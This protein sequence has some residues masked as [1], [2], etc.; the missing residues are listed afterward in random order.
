MRTYYFRLIFQAMRSRP[1]RIVFLPVFLNSFLLAPSSPSAQEP[2]VSVAP[3]NP[4]FSAYRAASSGSRPRLGAVSGSGRALGFIP[5]PLDFSH[6]K[7]KQPVVQGGS[8]IPKLGYAASYDLRTIGKTSSVKDQGDTCGSCW[9]F[10][11]MASLESRL[12]TG[13]SRDFSEN[14]LK[15]T[16]GFDYTPCEGGDDIMATAYLARWSGPWNETADPY[17]S[18]ENQ[19]APAYP[20][21]NSQ[22]HIQEVLFLP[23]RASATSND[24]IKWALTNYGA[25]STSIYWEDAS[26]NATNKSYIYTGASVVNHGVTIVG[27]DDNYDGSKFNT[28]PAGNGAFIIK[29]SWGSSW[30]ESGY[31]YLSY[32]DANI[33]YNTVYIGAEPNANYY[34]VYQYDPLG[35]ISAKGYGSTLAWFSNVFTAVEAN[36]QVDAVGFYTTDVNS[37]YRIFVYSDMPTAGNPRSGTLIADQTGSQA[38]V[39]YH[40]VSLN[41]KVPLSNGQKFTVVIMMTTSGYNYPIPVESPESGYS[42]GATAGAGQSYISPDGDAWSDLTL[43]YADTNANIKAFTAYA[44]TTDSTP[45]TVIALVKDGLSADIAYTTST[46]QLSANW[47]ASNDPES[48]IRRYWYAIGT[49]AGGTGVVDWTDNGN[50]ISVTKTGLGLTNGATYYFTVK[51][52]NWKGLTSVPANSNGQAIDST[53]PPGPGAVNDGMGADVTYIYLGTQL[54]ANWTPAV[55]PQSG[56]ARYW[57]AIGTTAGGTDVAGWTD[58]GTSTSVTKTGLSLTN[59]QIYY[60][61]V[62]AENKAGLRSSAVNSNGQTVDATAPSNPG[63][64]NDGL[65][66]DIVYVNANT[67]LSANWAPATDTESGIAKYWYMIG[68]STGASDIASWTDNGNNTSVTR[69]GLTLVNGWTYYFTVKAENW[70]GLQSSTVTSNGQKVDTTGPSN[71]GP[72]ND[73]I[74]VDITYVNSVSQLSANWSTSSD[75]QSGIAG[76]WYAIGTT[77]GGT[78]TL[79]WTDNGTS[80]SVTKTGLPLVNGGTYYFTVKVENGAGMQSSAVSSNGQTTDTTAPSDPGAVNDG[81]GVD[82]AYFNSSTEL[83]ANWVAAMDAESGIAR[84]WYAIGST[85]GGA[86]VVGWTNNGKETFVTKTGLSLTDGV[87][88]YFTVKAENG[89]GQQ[90]SA[91]NSNGQMVDSTAPSDPSPVNDGTGADI[92][93]TNSL[94]QLSANWT[95]ATDAQSGIVKYWYAIGSTTA[96]GTDV[97]GWT[98]N[99]N[100]IF[101]TRTGLDL[102]DGQ[103]YYF[104]VKAENGVGLRSSVSNSNGQAVDTTGPSNISAVNDGTG[105]D[106]SESWDPT[107]LSANWTAATDAQS[108]IARYWYAIGTTVGATDVVDWSDNGNNIAVTKAGLSLTSGVTYYFMVKAENGAGMQSSTSSSNGQLL[109]VDVTPP[110]NM[111]QVRDGTGSDTDWSGSWTQLSANWD[112]ATDAQSGIARYWYAIGSTPGATDVAG[113]T[114]NGNN[115]SVT[116]TGLS[117]ADGQLCYFTVRAENRVGLLASGAS[118]DGQTVDLTAPSNPG[119]VN[120]G[121]EAYDMDY[122]NSVTQLSA[123]WTAATDV[124]SG[125]GKYWYAIGT[126]A[127]AADVANWT[128]N[129]NNMSVTKTGLSLTNG[130]TYYFTVTAEN[131]AGLQGF[132]LNSDGQTVDITAPS[133]PGAVN[134]GLGADMAY[135]SSTSQ[136]SANWTAAADPQSGIGRYWYAIGTAAGGINVVGW[137]DNGNNISVT[138][139][140]L[141][142]TNG[143]TYYFTV[144][145]ENGAG[146]HSSAVSSNGQMVDVTGPSNL[147]A[148]NDG[149]GAD[150]SYSSSTGQL[151]ANWTAA[152]DAQSGIGRYWYAIGT[153]AGGTDVADWT[154][155]GNK[156]FA[157][158][159]GLSL[160]DGQIY[161][162][163]VKAENGAGQHSSAVNSNGQ[164]VDVTGSSD[165]GPVNDGIGADITYVNS[166]IQLSANWTA[167]A[168]A[169]SGISRYWY[170]IGTTA[171][172]TNIAGW[173]DNGNST[174][175]TKT[176]LSLTNGATYYFTVK[177]ENGAGQ[178][179]SAVNSNGQKTDITPSSSPG[180]VNDGLGA[181]LAFSSTTSQLS[182][183]WIAATDAQSGIAKYWYAIG[184]STGATDVLT[185]TESDNSTSVSRV[186]LSLTNGVKYY[187]TVKAENGVGLQSVAS[188]SNGQMLDV[189]A[190]S[191]PGTV[192]DGIGADISETGALFQLSANW[193]AAADEQSGIAKYWYAIGTIASDTDVV[194]WTDNGANLSVTKTGLTLTNGQ[195][196]HFSIKAENAAGMQSSTVSSNG[197]LVNVDVT[198]PINIPDV[199]DGTGY[200]DIVWSSS[201]TQLSA[202]WDESLDHESGIIRYWYAIGTTL[203]A[204]DV[205]D[206]TDNIKITSVTKTGLSLTNGQI[207]YFTVKGENGAGLKSSAT[208]SNGQTVDVT[209]PS[210]PGA[211]YDGIGADINYV[212]STGQLSANWTE[213]ADAQSGIVKYWYAI[214]TGAG[215]TDVVDWTDNGNNTSVTKSGLAL[216]NGQIYYFTVKAENGIGLRGAARNSNGQTVDTTAPSGPGVVNDGVGADI[217]CSG[218]ITQLS[219]NWT[220]ASDVQSGIAKYWY[221]IGTTTDAADVTD[222]TD[223]GDSLSVTAMGLSLTSGQT[224]YFMVKAENLTGQQSSAVNSN[225]QTVDTTVPSEPGAVNDGLG[226]D[227]TYVN[228]TSQLSANWIAAADAQSGIA[229]YWYAIGTATGSVDVVNWVDNGSNTFVTKTGLSLSIGATYY[230][231]VVAENGVGLQSSVVSS[232]GQSVNMDATPPANVP[233][234]R[235]GT[236]ADAYWAG[237]LTQLSANWDAS[238]DA[239]TGIGRYWY[240]I[241]T[242]AGGANVAAWTDNG[243]STS[244]TKT[245]LSLT[246]GATYYFTVKAENG[247]GLL[248]GAVNSN[249]QVVNTSDPSVPLFINDGMDMDEDIKYVPSL[250]NLSANWGASIHPSGID[251]Y[252]YSIGTTS[253]SADVTSWTNSGILLNVTKTGLS[254]T[255]GSTYY[256]SVRAYSNTGR[257]SSVAASDGQQVDVTSPTASIIVIST[258]P[259]GNGSFAAKLIVTEATGVLSST[260]SLGFITSSG[261]SFPLS[262]AWLTGSTWTATGFI[263]SYYSTGAVSFGLSAVDGAGN[264]GTLITSGGT[265]SIDTMLYG[266]TGGVMSNSDGFSMSVPAGVVNGNFFVSIS[267]VE[268]TSNDAADALSPNSLKLRISDLVRDFSIRDMFGDP[269]K[270]FSEPLTITLAYPDADADGRIDGDN[271]RADLVWIYWLDETAGK[272]TPVEGVVR[273]PGSNTLTAGVSHLS[274]YSIRKQ[275][276]T[277][278]TLANLKAYPNPCDFNKTGLTIVGIPP[279]ETGPGIY[280]F[281]SAGELVRSLKRGDGIGP[282]NEAL[283]DGRLKGGDRAASGLYIYLVRTEKYGKGIG[284]FFMLW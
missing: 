146:Q 75:A 39:G 53:A 181:D 91:V 183:N 87:T 108:G 45:P 27:W 151:S 9:T 13:E 186:G 175:A 157:T 252:E 21:A 35:Y 233:Q 78:D 227:V 67:A 184:F 82:I 164:T 153:T 15:N 235:D 214:G 137:T 90:S 128:D 208:N 85:Q 6:M 154:D 215:A 83:S 194:G 205:V 273:H 230:F 221:A 211:V 192:K 245:G 5:P 89:I 12:L 34:R 199:R 130:A 250:S 191:P 106:V 60:F 124:Q 182:A 93:Y 43:L 259:A 138:K 158:K 218:S 81:T 23:D 198:P 72:V 14:N 219:A 111:P 278:L 16:S 56:I 258:L 123:N 133:N 7:G 167:A 217:A 143:A 190:P 88:Y 213:A 119:A 201:L 32:Y 49:T 1:A 122:A 132:A 121:M 30:G 267:S 236:G 269:I 232:N 50:N 68:T 41:T 261:Q 248:S 94:S 65:A 203:G 179:S 47:T 139:A 229:K 169:Q 103:I 207:Y 162:F 127:G 180:A 70:V 200:Y 283:W 240:A 279:D 71:P 28:V 254:L 74:G 272:W 20:S 131:G 129:G 141:S 18:D 145:A 260:P 79:G 171:G 149:L 275:V 42:S 95:A 33:T 36:T 185:W 220:A 193:T 170:A 234:V 159:T 268:S 19:Q 255:E 38:Y 52:E 86:N 76:Y 116:K 155:N 247:V 66:A 109:S 195:T 231:S 125:I 225:G 17:S 61:T 97:A 152:S 212:N 172:G 257:Y 98:D 197:Q 26:Y 174:S 59:G 96:G 177:A 100:S 262:V 118:S 48:G 204:T 237:S 144:K 271:V 55:D 246:L 24:I 57:Y 189:T 3:L 173:T 73:G 11:A 160:T 62:K 134:D 277:S 10:A 84:Y 223:N 44:N 63:A 264:T 29:N 8:N 156:I 4:A 136:L 58:N 107:R 126:T 209:A 188:N 187:F 140:G 256:F 110:V 163:M 101:V 206:W 114:D 77:V 228:S 148:V 150:V 176:G 281:N 37:N 265:F 266:A 178:L 249:G 31:F 161:Y 263:E 168:D 142:L 112:A 165:F 99:G 238:S 270:S 115:L 54:S 241:G 117:L 251:H 276:S 40:T 274:R 216:T 280:I 224:Y 2:H 210:S 147:G 80:T 105:A 22:K 196:Y 166:I 226:Y 253:G 120:D 46:S 104:T 51:A 284:K 282:L 222:W 135:S 239:Q 242:T 64:V 113:W 243:N 202:N 25:V 244:A 69:S 92:A 102:R